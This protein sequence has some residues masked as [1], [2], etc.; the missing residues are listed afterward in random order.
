MDINKKNVFSADPSEFLYLINK[1]ELL[2]TD[3]FHGVIFSLIM[4]TPFIVFE[5][6]D[7]NESMESRLDTLLSLFRME[8]R[9]NENIDNSKI[10]DVDFSN[11]DFILEN[12]RNKAILYLKNSMNL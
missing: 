2:C 1:C 7:E 3:S 9:L 12:E 5:R 10:F 11:V 6:K 4:K 8:S